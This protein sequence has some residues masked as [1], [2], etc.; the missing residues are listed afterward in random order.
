MTLP[1]VMEH[2]GTEGHVCGL[3]CR[4]GPCWGLQSCYSGWVDAHGPGWYLWPV[5]PQGQ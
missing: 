2:V 5:L 1:E 4:P 3:C